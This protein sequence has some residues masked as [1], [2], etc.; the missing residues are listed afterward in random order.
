MAGDI[1]LP[2][3]GT[4]FMKTLSE[5]K[6]KAFFL[7]EVCII[8]S[9]RDIYE[10]ERIVGKTPYITATA[11]QNGIGYFVGN[12]NETLEADCI[13]VNRNGSVGYA[14]FHPYPALYGNDTRKL[15]PHNRNK[16]VAMFLA[17][18]ITAQK[19][20]Y[21][22]GLKMGT[23]RLRRQKIMLP[24]DEKGQPNYMFMEEYMKA[25]EK[26]LLTQ[27]KTYLTRVCDSDQT[28]GGKIEKTRWKSFSL[29][30]ICTIKSGV[31]LVS[32]HMIDGKMPFIG[33]ADSNNGLTRFVGN[34][35]SSLDS[36]VLG[37]NYNGNGVAIGFYHPYKAIFTDDVKRIKFKQHEGNRY[38]YLFLKTAI[39]KQKSKYQYG[40][41]FS[42]ER[43]NRQKIVLP[44]MEDDSIDF[45][46][47]ESY[48]RR[49]ETMLLQR[50]IDKRLAHS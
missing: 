10:R 41:K 44:V 29:N 22:Y 17:R 23:A 40:Y 12:E 21:G 47:M 36:N 50:Y 1:C 49:Q 6:W 24:V 9:G 45:K 25:V 2:N 32:R 15:I 48:M 18:S 42:G 16:Y 13:S 27:Y 38:V 4:E 26:R 39:L 7:E 19:D 35:N 20:K 46:Y 8:K 43:M 11:E 14:F 30:E 33:A 5:M 31:R 34:S 28:G 37:V 3:K